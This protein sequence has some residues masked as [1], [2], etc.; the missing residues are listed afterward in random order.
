MDH[1]IQL[2]HSRALEMFVIY[3]SPRDYPGKFVLRRWII[4]EGTSKPDDSAIIADTLE[5]IRAAVPF[6]MFRLERDPQDEPQIVE[7]WV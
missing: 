5:A 4:D 1:R 6:G 3:N 7:S 2:E